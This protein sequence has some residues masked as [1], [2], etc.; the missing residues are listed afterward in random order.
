MPERS[1]MRSAL[2][3]MAGQIAEELTAAVADAMR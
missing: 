1:Y 3:E 2:A